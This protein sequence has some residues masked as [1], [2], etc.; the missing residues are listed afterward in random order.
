MR[1]RVL[2]HQ[3]QWGEWKSVKLSGQDISFETAG[4]IY[5]YR[6]S[7]EANLDY[8]SPALNKMIIAYNYIFESMLNNIKNINSSRGYAYEQRTQKPSVVSRTQWGARKPKGSYSSHTPKKI[9]IHHTWRPTASQYSGSNS[10]KNI[11][12]YHMDSNGWADIG[13]HFLIG[14]YPNSGDTK[15]YQGRPENVIGAHTGGANTNNVG[16]NIVG[17][18]TTEKLHSKSYSTLIQLLAWLCSHYNIST[19]NIYGHCDF[20]STACPGTNVYKL[21]SQIRKDVKNYIN[22]G[23][24]N[25]KGELKGVI[26][27]GKQGTG[28]KISNAK[29]TVK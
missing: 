29:V 1:F 16:V 3:F 18:Y 6:I 21:L 15:I 20:G 25:G 4:T 13:Y 9:T 14:T 17:D 10:I 27:D 5:Q 26:Y 22:G 24:G 2:N 19:N 7:M 23:G 11:Q 12:N 8:E 28:V